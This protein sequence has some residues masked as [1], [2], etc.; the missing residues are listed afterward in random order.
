MIIEFFRKNLIKIALI[1][2]LVVSTLLCI[3]TTMGYRTN[4]NVIQDKSGQNNSLREG[5]N[6]SSDDLNKIL[7]S[8][9][10]SQHIGRQ[11]EL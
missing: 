4:T 7:R 10:S 3:Y 1:I 5:G 11:T 9:D 8:E 6:Q 2:A